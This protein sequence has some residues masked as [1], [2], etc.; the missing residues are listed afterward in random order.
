MRRVGRRPSAAAPSVDLIVDQLAAGT[1]RLLTAHVDGRLVGWLHL[2]REPSALTGHWGS[3]HH[4]Q[5]NPGFRRRGIGAALMSEAQRIARKEM[6]LRQLHLA[7]RGSLID[8]GPAGLRLSTLPP[9]SSPCGPR[10]HRL[11]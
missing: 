3:V 6:G 4:V 10:P 2:R 1:S 9:P 8:D 7:A 11:S 5:S